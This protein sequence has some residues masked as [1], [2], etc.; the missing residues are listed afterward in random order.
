M[1]R[2]K[3]GSGGVGGGVS[4]EGVVDRYGVLVDNGRI[5]I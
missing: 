4:R 2:S 1:E 3:S 5:V